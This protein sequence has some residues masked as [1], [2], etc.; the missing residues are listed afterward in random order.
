MQE[1]ITREPIT[2]EIEVVVIGGGFGG[3]LAGAQIERS[4]HR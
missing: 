3:M 4:W 1:A 2:E